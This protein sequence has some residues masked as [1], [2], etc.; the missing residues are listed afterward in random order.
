MRASETD[1]AGRTATASLPTV[2][3]FPWSAFTAVLRTTVVV[4]VLLRLLRLLLAALGL[5]AGFPPVPY[6][7]GVQTSILLLTVVVGLTLFDARRMNERV[8]FLDLGLPEVAVGA[9]SLVA[10]FLF[11]ILLFVARSNLTGG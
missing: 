5:V 4:W 2:P 10:A 1:S 7:G 9:V 11:E 3:R 6:F 8:F